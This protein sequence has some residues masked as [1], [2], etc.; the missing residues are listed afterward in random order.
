MYDD[1]W[2][3][4]T[5]HG[6]G[7]LITSHRYCEAQLLVHALMPVST[8]H[9]IQRWKVLSTKKTPKP[10]DRFQKWKKITEKH[11]RM[12]YIKMWTQKQSSQNGVI[13]YTQLSEGKIRKITTLVNCDKGK[14]WV[15][16]QREIS[17]ILVKW[18]MYVRPC[19]IHWIDIDEWHPCST[20][21]RIFP[22]LK[23]ISIW[24]T[25]TEALW[26]FCSSWSQNGS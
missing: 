13:H 2:T 9:G 16:F 10:K 22:T 12:L 20:G 18:V 25:T 6:Q 24:I 7:Q 23:S 11:F 5:C 26:R 1:L 19:V 21:W 4:S 17:D 15:V 3:R 14:N 8:I